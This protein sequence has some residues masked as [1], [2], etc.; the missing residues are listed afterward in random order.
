[1][2]R[3]S[4]IKAINRHTIFKDSK[5]LLV[6]DKNRFHVY[7][8]VVI[9]KDLQIRIDW[10]GDST[11]TFKKYTFNPDEESYPIGDNG[12]CKLCIEKIMVNKLHEYHLFTF[13]CRTV[14]F[15]I[16]TLVGFDGTYIYNLYEHA[17]VLCGL[18]ESECLS[19]K[20]MQHF[21]D[22]EGSKESVCV[23]S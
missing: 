10:N 3:P 8:A 22:N 14:S 9:N 1:M 13:N 17:N 16:L 2:S 12:F 7:V 21:F 11:L 20:E 18:E 4:P 6:M 5:W 23:I 19:I 15:L